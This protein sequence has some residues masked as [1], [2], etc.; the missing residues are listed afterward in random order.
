M[1]AVDPPIAHL[2][3]D[4]AL[5][6][7]VRYPSEPAR[8][9]EAAIAILALWALDAVEAGR[10][11]RDEANR[12]FVLLD[13]RLGEQPGPELSGEVHDL[14]TE[15]EHFH[16]YR[17]ALGVDP[18]EIRSLAFMILNPGR[19][20]ADDVQGSQPRARRTG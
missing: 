2:I 12:V 11:D 20:E 10:M 17:E 14:I 8:A 18:D 5:A 3:H 13:V 6:V 1:T 4:A 19:A 16:H 7:A 15:G 9:T